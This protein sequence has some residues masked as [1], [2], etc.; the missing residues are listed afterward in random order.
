MDYIILERFPDDEEIK[1]KS[2]ELECLQRDLAGNPT[3][4]DLLAKV[5]ALQDQLDKVHNARYDTFI[6]HLQNLRLL[7][8]FLR[9]IVYQKKQSS[10]VL[11]SL[12]YQWWVCPKSN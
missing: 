8:R 10:A 9:S 11:Y 12:N 5:R 2:H 4:E 6:F 3:D 1:A 7:L